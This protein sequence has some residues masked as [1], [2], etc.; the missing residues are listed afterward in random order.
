MASEKEWQT[1]TTE[2]LNTP[3]GKL[4]PGGANNLKLMG[5]LLQTHGLVDVE[6]KVEALQAVAVEMR[7]RGLDVVPEKKMQVD[8]DASPAEILRKWKSAL[9]DDPARIGEAFREFFK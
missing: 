3:E 7:E 9:G 5:Y 8:A 2:F 4:W 1:A 6:N